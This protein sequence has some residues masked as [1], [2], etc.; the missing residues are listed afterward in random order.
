MSE[1]TEVAT[2]LSQYNLRWGFWRGE[3]HKF[4]L[5]KIKKERQAKSIYNETST[6]VSIQNKW[7]R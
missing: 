6:Q 2:P 7:K 4:E 1:K 5:F 3:G